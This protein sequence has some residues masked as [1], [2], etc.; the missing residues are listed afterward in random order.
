MAAGEIEP[1]LDVIDWRAEGLGEL[2]QG[3]KA[4]R[5]AA[6]ELGED[7]RPLCGSEELCG[8]R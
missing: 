7:H 4:R 8:A 1:R 3:V 6:D 2:N 5:L